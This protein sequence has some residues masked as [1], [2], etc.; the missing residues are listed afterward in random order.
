MRTMKKLLQLN[1]VYIFLLFLMVSVYPQVIKAQ[2]ILFYDDFELDRSYQWNIIQGNWI[3]QHVQGSN[4][5]G[6]ILTTPSSYTGSQAGEFTL[7]NYEFS[8]DMLPVQGA[9]RN[10]FFRV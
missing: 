8:F 6:L 1:F 10:V 4:R 5:Y 3:R 2:A 9:D 7:T